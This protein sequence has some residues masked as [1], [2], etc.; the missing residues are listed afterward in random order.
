[1]RL[2]EAILRNKELGKW[3]EIALQN[4]QDAYRGRESFFEFSE[5]SEVGVVMVDPV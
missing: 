1:M 5:P 3:S 2:R 4:Q